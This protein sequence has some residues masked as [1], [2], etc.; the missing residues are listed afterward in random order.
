MDGLV[1]YEGVGEGSAALSKNG[2]FIYF[3][4]IILIVWTLLISND[5]ISTFIYFQF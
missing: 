3:V 2:A 1:T 5:M 4:W